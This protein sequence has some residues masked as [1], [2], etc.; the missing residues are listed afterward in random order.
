MNNGEF[1]ISLERLCS[2]RKINMTAL[3][4]VVMVGETRSELIPLANL[5]HNVNNKIGKKVSSISKIQG[6]RCKESV[7]VSISDGM[8]NEDNNAS[9][10]SILLSN[11]GR[12]IF[13]DYKRLTATLEDS[14]LI[15]P[16]IPCRV[17]SEALMN[18]IAFCQE[19]KINIK[20]LGAIII[21]GE[22][23]REKIP[24]STLLD[25][26]NNGMPTLHKHI[27][28]ILPRSE[29]LDI[30]KT[31]RDGGIKEKADYRHVSVALDKMGQHI[32]DSFTKLD[33]QANSSADVTNISQDSDDVD[34]DKVL[35]ER[36]SS[37]RGV[38]QIMPE[39]TNEALLYGLKRAIALSGGKAFIVI[40]PHPDSY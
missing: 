12:D 16:H 20:T 27:Q 28:S 33:F 18:I 40:P 6:S 32:Y 31:A 21:L 37:G 11:S 1:L 7:F 10:N 3:C 15:N 2:K 35:R 24:A 25:I 34:M 26:I 19:N 9:H 17:G 29:R 22:S 23:G 4:A 38:L 8:N 36:F 30:F 13:D 14:T 39:M 5:L